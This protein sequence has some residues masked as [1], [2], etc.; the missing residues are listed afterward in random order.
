MSVAYFIALDTDDP[1][2]DAFVDGKM[3]TKH[4]SHINRVA[5]Q[6]GLKQFE[7]YASQDLS[8]FGGPAMEETWF[9]P[10][11]GLQW[12]ETLN[13]YLQQHPEAV[14]DR[15]AVLDDLD[16]YIV[17]FRQAESLG[18]QWHLELDL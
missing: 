8:E 6:L 16:D 17:A 7:D 15:E 9:E 1:G 14:E 5:Q 2:F 13:N 18:H 4:L 3:L 12:A 10:S 11:E